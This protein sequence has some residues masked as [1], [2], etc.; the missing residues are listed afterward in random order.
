MPC[1]SEGDLLKLNSDEREVAELVNALVSGLNEEKEHR[2]L[3]IKVINEAVSSG[4]WYMDI[5][6][7]L[8]VTRAIWSDDFRKMVGFNDET[9]FPNELNSWSDRLHPDDAENTLNSFVACISDL[10]GQTGYDVNYR[11]RLKDDSYRWFRAAGHTIRD[12][13]G[14]PTEVLGVFIDIDDK[15]NKDRELDYTLNRYELIDSILTE[16]SWNMRIVG[17]PTNP[18]NE[19]WWSN[20][21][22]RLLGFKD[23]SDFPNVLSSWSDRLHPDDKDYTLKAFN[24]H[25]MDYTGRTK[26]DLE[27][28]LAKKDGTYRWFRAVGDTLRTDDGAPILVAGAIEDISLK[29]EKIEL[30]RTLNKMLQDLTGAI[31]EIT[32]S[33]S[34]TTSKTME[35]SKEADHMTG[36]AFD[37]KQKT[38]E[39]LKMIKFIMDISSQTNLLALNA[40][41]E[42][43]R[44]GDAGKGFAVVAEEVGKLAQSSS[45]VVEKITNALSGMEESVTNITDRIGNINGL[46]QTQAANMEEIN[47]SI[48][49]VNATATRLSSL[50]K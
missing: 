34:D 48:E 41:I 27:Y 17:D 21:F 4:L 1:I 16:G 9:D 33:I 44:A 46:V 14:K 24:D 2:D 31:D 15:I 20:Q 50:A 26:F 19:F 13:S 40:S 3:R 39:T 18:D 12:E 11:L 42:A 43:A 45:E 36:E 38:D 28:R 29:K 5:D 8:N 37:S 49:E 30:D 6:E 47:A 23:E 22:R 10:S 7:N 25:L 35:I 32:K